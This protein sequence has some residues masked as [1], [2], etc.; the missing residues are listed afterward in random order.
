MSLGSR[1]RLAV[2]LRQDL[3]QQDVR[4]IATK[5]MLVGKADLHPAVVDL[6]IDA[7]RE[8]HSDQGFSR[9]PGV[10]RH[11]ARGFA[12]LRRSD[13]L[14]REG[15][16]FLH[17]FFPFWVGTFVERL[18][19][20]AVPIVVVIAPLIRWIPKIIDWQFT[21]HIVRWYRA[22]ARLE[23]DVHEHRGPPATERWAGERSYS[24]R[25]PANQRSRRARKQGLCAALAYPHRRQGD[26]FRG[27]NKQREWRIGGTPPPSCPL[28]RKGVIERG[29]SLETAKVVLPIVV[30]TGGALP[31]FAQSSGAVVGTAPGIASAPREQPAGR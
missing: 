7:T 12:G 14:F 23:T 2:D 29:T 27:S 5:A 21:Q 3:P 18:I 22:L 11:H 28:R 31:C 20:F 24:A 16:T 26:S 4:L 6:L 10:P 9:P 1:C 17:R 8:I 15:P 19:V 30:A 13:P 25:C